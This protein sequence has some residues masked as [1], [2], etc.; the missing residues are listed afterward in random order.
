MV[1]L[2]QTRIIAQ[3]P[4]VARRGGTP[5]ADPEVYVIV[6][7]TKRSSGTD[8]NVPLR[9]V[10]DQAFAVRD[11]IRL[12][13]GRMFE[14]GRTELIVGSGVLREFAGFD[15]G[16]EVRLGKTVWTVVGI[17]DA[18][19]T[20]F[21]SEVWADAQ[22]IQNLYNRGTSY[23]V[24]R[25]RLTSADAIDAFNAFLEADP[26]LKLQAQSERVYLSRQAEALS[27]VI[28]AI[29]WPIAITMALGALAGA[30]NTMYA[31]VAARQRE[32]GTL[33]AIGFGG[34]ATFVGT[35]VE[36]LI[37]ASAG[38]LLGAVGAYLLFQDMTASTLGGSFTQVVFRF[39]M[40]PF[41]AVQGILLAIAVGLLGG[42]PPALR[43]ARVP[44]VVAFRDG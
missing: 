2:D 31:S 26:R 11:N 44:V 42:I 25:V 36:S 38:G 5:L 39:E 3:A 24:D 41:V 27:T 29:G 19:G 30:L 35:L 40:S 23:Q 13:A 37:L 12:V 15:L 21:E 7:G 20:V 17:F 33:R 18:G 28:K 14:P 10:S 1:S 32:I 4:Q 22:V 9:G 8:V 16:Q 43:A 6:N 34:F